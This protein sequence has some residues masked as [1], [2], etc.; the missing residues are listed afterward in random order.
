[1]SK[2]LPVAG[3]RTISM[4]ASLS[5]FGLSLVINSLGNVLTIVTS[6]KVHPSFLGSA[7]W[8]AAEVNLGNA[9]H[10]SLFWA[11]LS[12]GFLI[13][14]LNCVLVGKFSIKRVLGNLAFMVPF[15]ALIQVFADF[16]SKVLPEATTL[17]MIL[18]YVALNFLGVICIG[19]AIS[20]Y[21]RVNLVLHPADDLMQILRFKYCHGKAW[22]AMLVSYVPPTIMAIVAFLMTKEFANFGIGTLFAFAFQGGVTGIADRLIIPKLKH[23]NVDVGHAEAEGTEQSV[24]AASAAGSEEKV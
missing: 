17:P 16:F 14:L 4:G 2:V 18:L 22:I 24:T 5:Y 21:Q 15:S 19:T 7:Y 23:Q 20:I 3:K 9:L 1:M 8:T 6:A 11:F 13:T 12:L 10:I